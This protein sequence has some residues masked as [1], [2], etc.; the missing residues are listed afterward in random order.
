MDKNKTGLEC[1]GI[2]GLKQTTTYV[3][4]H[5]QE[6]HGRTIV[7]PTLIRRGSMVGVGGNGSDCRESQQLH[8]HNQF[9]GG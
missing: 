5:T 3:P 2:P 4:Q 1:L 9:K 7:I 8:L 6:F